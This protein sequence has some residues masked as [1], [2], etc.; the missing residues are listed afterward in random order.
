ML[1]NRFIPLCVLVFG[2]LLAL[3][4]VAQAD[5]RQNP[6][7]WRRASASTSIPAA[8]RRSRPHCGYC[9]ATSRR[10]WGKNRSG[11]PT[12][13][14]TSRVPLVIL[15]G[16]QSVL[17]IEPLTGWER[18]KIFVKDGRLILQGSDV[19]GTVYAV[20]AFSEQFLGVKPLWFWASQRFAAGRDRGQERTITM[21]PASLM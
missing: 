9:S 13:P 20:L 1:P 4:A 8:N 15:T 11:V 10:F 12:S 16:A 19:L 18:H 2:M 5:E 7:F 17:G 21:T 6:S 14:A 3:E